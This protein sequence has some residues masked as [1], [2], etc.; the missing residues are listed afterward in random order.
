M[1]DD[2]DL[3]ND[4][5]IFDDPLQD[6]PLQDDPLQD[7][8]LPDVTFAKTKIYK[9]PTSMSKERKF[10]ITFANFE[11]LP[12]EK[13][14]KVKSSKFSC[15]GHQWRVVIY[16]GGCKTSSDGMLGIILK[17]AKGKKDIN[18]SMAIG[19]KNVDEFEFKG[20]AKFGNGKNSIGMGWL[21]IVSRSELLRAWLVKGALTI[22]V[23]LQ[24]AEF[25]PKNPT[26]TMILNL[27]ADESSADVVFEISQQQKAEKESD[28]KKRA[29]ISSA[30][31]RAHRLIIQNHSPELAALCATSEGMTPILINDIKPDVFRHLLYYVYGGEISEENFRTHAKDLINAADKYGVANL[32]LASE[33]WYVHNT[34]ITINNVIDNLLYSDSMNCALLKEA[35]MD[36]FLGNKKEVMERVSFQDVP[37][38]ICRDLLAAVKMRYNDKEEDDDDEEEDVYGEKKDDDEEIEDDEDSIEIFE[39]DAFDTMQIGELRR[40]AEEKGLDIDVSRDSLIAALKDNSWVRVS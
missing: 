27:F 36:F 37:G 17:R 30:E 23:S 5:L 1:A 6:D 16:P 25:I 15:F 20:P 18:I 7:D 40:R 12:S 34:E 9:V 19:V 32:K 10:S 24:L 31:F 2:D 35:V 39:E 14:H 4:D 3:I 22:Y 38:N 11:Y 21:D 13:G 26:S 33:V 28:R 29:T 8:P